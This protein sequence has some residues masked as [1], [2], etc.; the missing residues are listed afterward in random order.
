MDR[1]K[2]SEMAK[3]IN[4]ALT[5]AMV[6][7]TKIQT[8]VAKE[9]TPPIELALMLGLVNIWASRQ[10]KDWPDIDGFTKGLLEYLD[11]QGQLDPSC[12]RRDSVDSRLDAIT[13]GLDGAAE[14]GV[15]SV[16]L[17]DG[18]KLVPFRRKGD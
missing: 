7:A 3:D 16:P 14:S 5:R 15:D 13:T 11:S 2:A 17:R 12:G 4:E 10:I 8:T 1:K 9:C 6:V 18:L